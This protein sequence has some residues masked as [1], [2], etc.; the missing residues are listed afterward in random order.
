MLNTP[1]NEGQV[2]SFGFDF[3]LSFLNTYV[4][5]QLAEGKKAYDNSKKMTFGDMAGLDTTGSMQS[6]LNFA[7][8]QAPQKG[9][10]KSMADAPQSNPLFMPKEQP[11][12]TDEGLQIHGVRKVWGQQPPATAATTATV[13][14]SKVDSHYNSANN[15]KVAANTLENQDTGG[16]LA[17]GGGSA[18]AA[19]GAPAKKTDTKKEKL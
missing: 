15:L 3:E 17:F 4:Q 5:N 9:F 8:Y 1:L 19:K 11:K 10:N 18:A 6:D 7:P 14:T 2:L 16:S 13:D 12:N